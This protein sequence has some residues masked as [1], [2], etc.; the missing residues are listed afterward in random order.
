MK[1]EKISVSLLFYCLLALLPFASMAGVDAKKIQSN[2]YH[3]FVSELPAWVADVQRPDVEQ[4]MSMEGESL[5]Y[6]L[7]DNQTRLSQQG[8]PNYFNRYAYVPVS[9]A[10][11]ADA[12]ELQILFNPEYQTLTFHHIRVLREGKVFNKLNENEIRL[13]QRERDIEKR[14]YDGT[15]TALV[16]LDDIRVGDVIEY[17]YT[18][19]G[20]NPV[21][22]KKLNFTYSL[23]WG[24]PVEHVHVRMLAHE[25]HAL[26]IKVH[27]MALEHSK[28]SQGEF[29]DYR[30]LRE[31]VMPI[32]SD[33]DLPAWYD[34]YPWLQISQYANWKD[35][36][37]WA[38]PLYRIE[39]ELSAELLA[40]VKR[41]KAEHKNFEDQVLQALRF[42][43]EDVRYF[44]VEFGVNTHRP[45]HP[46]ETFQRRFGDCKD[47]TLLF[48][49]ILG[50]LGLKAYPALVS[51]STG[52]GIEYEL[53]SPGA[54]DH[55]IT[56]LEFDGK[57]YWLDG[58]RTHQR[59]RLDKLGF[60]Y[61]AKALVIKEG[62]TALWNVTPPENYTR[63]KKIEESFITED[64]QSPVKYIIRT[65]YIGSQA[66]AQRQY[67][68]TTSRREITQNYLN[69]LE[70]DYP[71]VT[72]ASALK[73]ED[74]EVE[75]ILS[76]IEEYTIPDFWREDEGKFY[77]DVYAAY[78]NTFTKLPQQVNRS[79]PL[80]INYPITVTQETSIQYPDEYDFQIDDKKLEI[81]NHAMRYERDTLYKGK[82]LTVSFK[83][84]S[85]RP[86][87][88]VNAVSQ[89]V[90]Q[91]RQINDDLSHT[92][93]V[94]PG[95]GKQAPSFFNQDSIDLL[96]SIFQGVTSP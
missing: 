24:V 34:P 36:V 14:L 26:N 67:F 20:A 90:T 81:E 16:I 39:G 8:D 46:N 45:H 15:V 11:L 50:E 85:K 42:V 58:T 10:G 28:V 61:Y 43:Q 38:V 68:A 89:H 77:A 93:W 73:V 40:R 75:N 25:D 55:V 69:Y 33:G 9:A 51:S 6:L 3:Y 44:G 64:Y 79:M 49:G 23:G 2:G 80:Y 31:K 32:Y 71:G 86:D 96:K 95:S 5:Y 56:Y 91:L 52:G 53:P 65:D 94:Q 74:D 84:Q 29:V 37:D 83:Y 19:T 12:S 54:F 70:H 27:G 48:I 4:G 17:A 41:W 1:I 66:E 76:V 59:G 92:Y 62:N 82:T 22:A 88:N 78:I 30:W 72:L 87:V 7:S 21:F 47:K 35:V 57:S 60:G 18:I 63:A 13:I